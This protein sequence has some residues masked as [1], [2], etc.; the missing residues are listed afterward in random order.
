VVTSLLCQE[1]REAQLSPKAGER[2]QCPKTSVSSPITAKPDHERE[3]ISDD[4]E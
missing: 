2:R 3:D 1:S 4:R